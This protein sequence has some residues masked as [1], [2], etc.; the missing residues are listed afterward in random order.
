MSCT[1]QW[2]AP[3][4]S[5]A[6]ACRSATACSGWTRRGA[7]T[8]QAADRRPGRG[9]RPTRRWSRWVRRTGGAPS[10]TGADPD[11]PLLYLAARGARGAARRPAGSSSRSTTCRCASP[12]WPSATP[13]SMI[14]RVAHR[15]PQPRPPRLRPRPGAP[16]PASTSGSSR[17]CGPPARWSAWCSPRSPPRSASPTACTRGRPAPPTCTPRRSGRVPSSTTRRTWRSAPRSWISCPVPFKKTDVFRQIASVPGL[18]PDRLP[19]RQQPRDRRPVP[20]VVPRQRRGARRRA[21]PGSDAPVSFD[22]L[23]ALAADG[24]A[25]AAAT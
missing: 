15:Q 3:C 11:R 8:R 23:T 5:T 2:P 25:R 17:R 20:A 4:R 14:G 22:D 13:A 19:R 1:G 6:R 7:P 24:G 12:A 21:A 18:T 16:G 10:T 9:L